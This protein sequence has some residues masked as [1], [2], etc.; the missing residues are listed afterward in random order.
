MAKIVWI[1]VGRR[2]PRYAR[3]NFKLTQQM[4]DRN[5][6]EL[7]TDST[8]TCHLVN[9]VFLNSIETSELTKEFYNLKR[10]SVNHQDYFWLGTTARFFHLYDYMLSKGFSSAIHAE[11]DVIILDLEYLEDLLMYGEFGLAFPLQNESLG[12]AS[13]FLVKKISVLKEF[14]EFI[15]ENWVKPRTTDMSLLNDFS[16]KGNVLRLPSNPDQIIA[17]SVPK[18]FDAGTLGPF[19]MG[20][21][22]RNHRWPFSYRGL[23]INSPFSATSRLTESTT[24]W[25]LNSS[26]R[27]I[28]LVATSNG[29]SYQLVNLHLHSKKVPKSIRE[30]RRKI[31]SGFISARTKRWRS[32]SFDFVVFLERA[33]SYI[34]R[35][36]SMRSPDKNFR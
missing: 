13:V 3:R 26:E 2:L 9:T 10:D 7:V 12:V 25:R 4:Y 14:L 30:A 5:R 34:L 35:R 16:N 20:T 8:N 18:I 21:D 23:L 31:H 29:I 32:G 15:L 11:T 6:Q 17:G 24:R 36:L 28:N 33:V 27:A 1:E 19:F 22:P